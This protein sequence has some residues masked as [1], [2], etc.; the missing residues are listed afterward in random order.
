VLPLLS[1]DVAFLETIADSLSRDTSIADHVRPHAG[2]LKLLDL[3]E[4]NENG[5]DDEE[6][7]CSPEVDALVAPR[8][9][10]EDKVV[11]LELC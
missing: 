6:P 7:A 11:R 3:D 4:W 5:K 9:I 10:D 8:L 2:K 1:P